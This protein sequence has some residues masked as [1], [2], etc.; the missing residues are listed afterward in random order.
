MGSQ[1]L[2]AVRYFG[3]GTNRDRDMMV[4]M[5][6]RE[7]LAGR[8][9]RLRNYQLCIQTLNEIPEVVA[10]TAPA[11][12]SPRAIVEQALG[13][14]FEL[15]IVRPKSSEVTYG[16]IWD[17]TQDELALV[18]E[19]EL[20]DFG[21]QDEIRA[22]AI[23]LEG[24]AIHIHTHGLLTPDVRVDRVVAGGDYSD[25]LIK[26]EDIIGISNRVRLEYLE[27]IARSASGSPSGGE[28]PPK[29][30]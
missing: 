30:P 9:G 1:G 19:W 29:K 24:E 27:R 18:Y 2:Q 25:Y 15:Y 13:S 7:S 4:A 23:D 17:I 26:K 5:I 14:S 28:A 16:T 21:M 6:G 11:P 22:V 8:P 10:E 12:L 20:L 3:Y